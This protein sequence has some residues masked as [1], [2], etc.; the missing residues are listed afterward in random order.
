MFL[1][2]QT[3]YLFFVFCL[4]IPKCYFSV[5]KNDEQAFIKLKEKM[6]ISALRFV[7]ADDCGTRR[8]PLV[9]LAIKSWAQCLRSP[10]PWHS[11]TG[12]AG[13]V[14]LEI[15][16]QELKKVTSHF[17]FRR[18]RRQG[19]L[20]LTYSALLMPDVCSTT[21]HHILFCS[22]QHLDVLLLSSQIV[23]PVVDLT[24]WGLSPSRL[25]LGAGEMAQWL[26][27]LTALPEVLSSI[28]STHVV[29]HNHL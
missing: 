2:L 25:S 9:R 21:T 8:L 29:T 3:L 6:D 12:K 13:C 15:L 20:T 27:E 14:I 4:V 1:L 22:R 16:I 10:S 5:F 11:P 7:C 23:E 24:G 28:P 26:R 18:Y 17:F 19:K